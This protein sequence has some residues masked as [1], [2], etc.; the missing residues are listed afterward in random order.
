M[1]RSLRYKAILLGILSMNICSVLAQESLLEVYSFDDLPRLQSE[2]QRP[3]FV[4]LTADWCRYCKNVEQNSFQNIEVVDRLN[5]DFYIVIFDIEERNE[6]KLFGQNFRYKST[7]LNTG[8]HEL[9][10]LIGTIDGVLN[11]PTFVMFDQS[12]QIQYQY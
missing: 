5:N 7:G 6:I 1:V 11:T 10:E 8:V 3:I 12:L 9:A 2:D 4:F